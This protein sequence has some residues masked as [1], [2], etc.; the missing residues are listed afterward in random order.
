MAATETT[1]N[2]KETDAADGTATDHT[3]EKGRPGPHDEK[4]ETEFGLQLG[5]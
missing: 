5:H 2:T 3:P 4:G 1:E